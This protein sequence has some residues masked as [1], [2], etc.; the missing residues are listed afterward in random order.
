VIFVVYSRHRSGDH[1]TL[2]TG[3]APGFRGEFDNALDCDLDALFFLGI[4]EVFDSVDYFLDHG[5]GSCVDTLLSTTAGKRCE[6]CLLAPDGLFARAL[7]ADVVT[8]GQEQGVSLVV[9]TTQTEQEWAEDTISDK[10]GDSVSHVGGAK[11]PGQ[12][13]SDIRHR[14]VL[15]LTLKTGC[16]PKKRVCERVSAATLRV[17]E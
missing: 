4:G 3:K 14:R 11:L 9:P 5:T 7:V 1:L 17:E 6:E 2:E 8:H 15:Q 16:P 10:L 12:S 13:L